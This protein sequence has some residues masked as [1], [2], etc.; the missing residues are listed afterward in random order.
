MMAIYGMRLRK[1]LIEQ[2]ASSEVMELICKH[3][4]EL[5]GELVRSP[6]VVRCSQT[7]DDLLHDAI[8]YVACTSDVSDNLSVI[9]ER[10]KHK[11]HSLRVGVEREEYARRELLTDRDISEYGEDNET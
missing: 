9:L 8:Y 2:T 10:V 5:R 6:D 3:Y 1:R 7:A 4:Y 11:Y